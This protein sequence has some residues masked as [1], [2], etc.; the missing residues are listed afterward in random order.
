MLFKKEKHEIK[1]ALAELKI[2]IGAVGKIKNAQN[3]ICGLE[4]K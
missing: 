2:H 4:D 3:K 1:S